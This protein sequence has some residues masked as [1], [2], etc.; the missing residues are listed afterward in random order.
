VLLV[1]M[2]ITQ[3]VSSGTIARIENPIFLWLSS[4]PLCGRP[5]FFEN[6]PQ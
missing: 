6:S 4:V 3:K 1:C 5:W 2:D